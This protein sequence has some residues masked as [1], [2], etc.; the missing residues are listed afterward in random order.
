MSNL[1]LAKFSLCAGLAFSFLYAGIASLI[2]PND[3]VGYLPSF[4]TSSRMELLKVFSVFEI[5]LGLWLL[6]GRYLK[7]TAAMSALTLA[8]AVAFN[9]G[10]F[11]VTFRDVGLILAS[12]ALFFLAKQK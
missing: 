10:L 11:I 7:Y 9:S 12:M 1:K 6:S 3:W 4:I 5:G 2:T 8:G